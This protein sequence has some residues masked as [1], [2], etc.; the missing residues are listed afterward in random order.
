[1]SFAFLYLIWTENMAVEQVEALLHSR[2]FACLLL[3]WMNV[4]LTRYLDCSA[5]K[6]EL[7]TIC[8]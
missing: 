8:S 2:R 3:F 6:L 1:M 5:R 7:R 4:D